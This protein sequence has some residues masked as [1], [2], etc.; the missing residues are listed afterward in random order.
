MRL[1]LDTEE[2]CSDQSKLAGIVLDPDGNP[3]ERIWIEAFY[4][5]AETGR[6]GAFKLSVPEGW[7]GPVILSIN[8]S[9]VADCDFVGYYDERDGFTPRR[10]DATR[11]EVG[12]ADPM[13]IKIILPDNPVGLCNSQG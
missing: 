9:E 12:Y 2:L 6:D 8:V 4:E 13:G 5:W 1:P 7:I 11:V 10:E 3:V